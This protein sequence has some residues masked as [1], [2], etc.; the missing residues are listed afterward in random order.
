[1]K[2]K[3]N[4]TNFGYFLEAKNIFFFWYKFGVCT[5]EYSS[6]TS[7]PDRYIEINEILSKQ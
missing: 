3:K 1:V 5:V 2:K 4:Q 6:V 7:L